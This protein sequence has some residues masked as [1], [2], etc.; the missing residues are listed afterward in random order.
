MRRQSIP[1]LG[2]MVYPE[3]RQ[4]KEQTIIDLIRY[5]ISR[6]TTTLRHTYTTLPPNKVG[7]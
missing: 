1:R 2:Q 7:Q 5:I 4:T 6:T 3:K